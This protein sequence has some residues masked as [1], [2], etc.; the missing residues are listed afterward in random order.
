MEL[1]D[2]TVSIHAPNPQSVRQA[3]R[4]INFQCLIDLC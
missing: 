2:W 1:P 4:V 3:A